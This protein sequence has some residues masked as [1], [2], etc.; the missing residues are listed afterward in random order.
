MDSRISP[1][2]RAALSKGTVFSLL[3]KGEPGTGKTMLAFEILDELGGKNA[4]YLS[5][6][7]SRPALFE[8]F[9]WLKGR[10]GFNVIDATKLIIS[11]AAVDK[12]RDYLPNEAYVKYKA[13]IEAVKD[14]S[15]VSP[16][17]DVLYDKLVDVEKPA[18]LVIDSWDAIPNDERD[19]VI[20]LLEA[21]IT[22]LEQNYSPRYKLNLILISETAG[23]TP[24][25]YVVDGIIV[26]TRISIDYRRAREILLKKLR[27]VRIDQHKYG[28]TLDGGRFRYFPPFERRKVEKP[29]RVEI[30]PNTATYLSTGCVE[31]DS[32]LDRGLSMGSTAIVEY[33]DD[34]SLLG[35]QS[36]IA[37]L[38]INSIQQR[39]HCVIIPSSGW[40]ERRLRRG[41]LPFVKEE[42]YLKYLTVFEIRRKK[43]EVRENVKVIEGLSMAE[44]FPLFTDYIAKLTHP[45]I[46]IIGTDLLEYQY[47]LKTLGNLEEALEIFAYWIMELSEAGDVA[48]FAMPTGGALGWG[49][50]HMVT[51]HFKL[52]VHDRS[53]LLYC[54]RPD[55]KLH[56]LENIITEDAL[57]L[58]LTPF[59]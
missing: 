4:I 35:Y 49:L 13:K 16:L 21:A 22:N 24:L 39:N 50:G 14:F 1:E 59:V 18:T 2:I 47:R 28:F 12:L 56:C 27:G 10:P 37:H 5:T 43:K 58:Q 26:L 54:N 7:V 45:V 23:T 31:L 25:D 30:V 41:I 3:I 20:E 33:E 34:L 52:V 29:R 57:K 40:D 51:T 17:L 38:I 44:D 42:D 32:I 55:T 6:R 48:V 9:P 8:Q 46:V 53:V 19:M 15:R 36:I 11:P